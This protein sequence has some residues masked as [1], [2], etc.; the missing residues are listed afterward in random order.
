MDMNTALQKYAEQFE[1]NFPLYAVRDKTEEEIVKLI[2]KAIENNEPYD[3]DY[4]KE[5]I[6]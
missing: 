1:D 3:A 4:G 6:Y 5:R 2:E